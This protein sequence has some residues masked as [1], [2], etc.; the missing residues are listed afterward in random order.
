MKLS[1]ENMKEGDSS[2]SIGLYTKII[3]KMS[4]SK[5]NVRVWN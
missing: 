5:E 3:L 2:K 1:S 4:L